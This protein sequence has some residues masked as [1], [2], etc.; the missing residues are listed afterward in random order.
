M[1]KV[2]KFDNPAPGASQ[3]SP[4]AWAVAAGRGL[5]QFDK[6]E[7]LFDD[8]PPSRVSAE[9]AAAYRNAYCAENPAFA[10]S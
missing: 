4:E 7:G 5:G 1:P 10:T 2:S 6:A 8:T 3:L 9:H